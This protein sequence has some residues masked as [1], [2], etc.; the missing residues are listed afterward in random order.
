MKALIINL[1]NRKL[2]FDFIATIPA[3]LI[4][5]SI[6]YVPIFIALYFSLL[7]K[8]PIEKVSKFVGLQ[9]Y[10]NLFS[11]PDFFN[12]LGH[13][14]LY[15]IGVTFLSFFSAFVI[16]SLL[17]RGVF[18][19]ETVLTLLLIP[20]M[21]PLV[22]TGITWKLMLDEIFGVINW[23]LVTLA[24]I[25]QRVDFLGNP[26]WGLFW[27]IIGDWWYSTPFLIVILYGGMQRVP[28]ELRSAAKVDGASELQI[29]RY[30]TV[31]TIIPEISLGLI[32]QT[33]FTFRRFDIVYVLTGGGPGTSTEV[34]ATW[35][36]KISSQ[37]LH[38]GYASAI[39]TVMLII[40]LIMVLAYRKIFSLERG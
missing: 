19:K 38:W 16:A 23:F 21:I 35:V 8:K 25:P 1:F 24:I 11:N 31:P 34:L 2:N 39:S 20:W 33:M 18:L 5:F 6:I 29:I 4:T 15:M 13:T 40:T 26:S 36:Y 27:V 10:T 37:Y 9:N 22:T 30:I 28:D 7:E 32:M 17:D 12:I 14:V 3:Q